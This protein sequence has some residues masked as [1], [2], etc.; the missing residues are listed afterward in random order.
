MNKCMY[1]GADLAEAA[2]FCTSC[3]KEQVTSEPSIIATQPIESTETVEKV[4][5]T[6]MVQVPPELGNIAPAMPEQVAINPAAPAIMPPSIGTTPQTAM[7]DQSMPNNE[8]P[9]LSQPIAAKKE[10]NKIIEELKG[11]LTEKF[12]GKVPT[13]TAFLIVIIVSLLIG[14]TIG[15][16]VKGGSRLSS[17]GETITSSAKTKKYKLGDSFKFAGYKLTTSKELELT[18]IADQYS[19]YNGK[20]IIKVPVIVQ[21]LTPTVGKLNMFYYKYLGPKGIEVENPA[22]S[23]TDKD[24]IDYSGELAPNATS[25]QLYFYILYAGDGKY[26]ISFDNL[27]EKAI[28]EFNVKK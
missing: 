12:V 21:N 23:I 26:T 17:S 9:V 7:L 1:C 6:S 5:P 3:G 16:A 19:S 20:E 25:E 24:S 4:E 22:I 8:T 27:E 13:W 2:K 14:F 18:T 28:I 15:S 11:K 10:P